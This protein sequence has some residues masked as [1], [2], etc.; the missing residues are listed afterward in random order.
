MCYGGETNLIESITFAVDRG[1][2]VAILGPSGAGKSTLL[3]M[4][5]GLIRNFEGSIL[6]NGLQQTQPSREIQLVFQNYRLFPWKKAAGNVAFGMPRGTRAKDREA[7]TWI[8]RVGLADKLNAWPKN[9]S[10][11]ETARLALARALVGHPDVLLLDEPFQSLDLLSRYLVQDVLLDALANDPAAVVMI[12]HSVD[13]AVFLADRIFLVSRRPMTFLKSYDV[14]VPRPRRRSD[15][16]LSML[17]ATIKRDI[18]QY[19]LPTSISAT[20]PSAVQ[21]ATQVR[22]GAV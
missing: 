3:R 16:Q 11:G 18:E 4:I 1:E 9:L 13:D 15:E 20:G 2:T 12:S 22:T 6:L 8:G 14:R 19:L 7:A 10:G 5:A 17:A 21:P